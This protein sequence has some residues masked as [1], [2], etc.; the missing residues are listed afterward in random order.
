MD[1][2]IA[3]LLNL[4]TNDSTNL[5]ELVNDFFGE[6]WEDDKESIEKDLSE[7][8]GSDEDEFDQTVAPFDSVMQNDDAVQCYTDH[9]PESIDSVE[10]EKA[11]KYSCDCQYN[12]GQPCYRRYTPEEMIRRRMDM[13]ELTPRDQMLIL[14]GKLSTNINL[15][16]ITSNSKRKEQTPRKT[17]QRMTYWLESRQICR[18]TFKFLHG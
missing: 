9:S 2:E 16:G 14:L 3:T 11:T 4:N 15:S 7:E 8:D 10:C 6:S 5:S 17:G 13:R 18:E 12:D 1:R